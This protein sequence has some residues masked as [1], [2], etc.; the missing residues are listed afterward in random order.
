[1]LPLRLQ[2]NGNSGHGSVDPRAFGSLQLYRLR[3]I[4]L[5]EEWQVAALRKSLQREVSLWGDAAD[6]EAG[7]IDGR[8][9][10]T[11]GRTR[12]ERDR[13]VAQVVRFWIVVLR[14]GLQT[15]CNDLAYCLLIA[16]DGRCLHQFS[17]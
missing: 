16:G 8:N 6:H 10:Q 12:A 14:H 3:G 15:R 4:K 5:I 13:D 2:V 7:L 17:Q 11:P 9:Q 1:M